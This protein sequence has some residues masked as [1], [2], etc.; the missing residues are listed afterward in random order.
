MKTLAQSTH[1]PATRKGLPHS[2]L[3]AH[4]RGVVLVIALILLV[5]ISL[6]AVTNVRNASSTA[7]VAGNVRITELATQAAD[8]ALRHCEASILDILR[9]ASGKPST[10]PST[11]IASNIL[12]PS[13]PL[14]WQDKAN[15]DT[16][17]LYYVLPLSLV[18]QTGMT[19]ATYMRPPECMAQ[20]TDSVIS[21]IT[22][23][24]TGAVTNITTTYYVVTARGFGPEVVDGK[25]RPVGSEIW[26]Q[27]NISILNG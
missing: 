25:G 14:K 2:R 7:N 8:I 6:L 17:P 19:D 15:W 27:S 23:S 24:V 11:F 20:L 26:L 22:D 5:V 1:C 9:V 18:N 21:T 4:Q 3:P 16:T 10:Y 12:Q 13:I